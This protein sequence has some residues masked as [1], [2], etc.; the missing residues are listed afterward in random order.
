MELCI[1]TAVIICLKN[2]GLETDMHCSC[3]PSPRNLWKENRL[4]I[5]LNWFGSALVLPKTCSRVLPPRYAPR[6]TAEQGQQFMRWACLY[7][8]FWKCWERSM[9]RRCFRMGRPTVRV[10]RSYNRQEYVLQASAPLSLS[11]VYQAASGGGH[12][13]IRLECNLPH[14]FS[15]GS[16]VSQYIQ[17]AFFLQSAQRL[18]NFTSGHTFSKPRT[19]ITVGTRGAARWPPTPLKMSILVLW[20]FIL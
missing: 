7:G 15:K 8:H 17:S 11:A 13:L 19:G 16:S 10:S 14:S 9:K 1:Y 4:F 2:V 6:G 20:Q 18:F 12:Q 3:P 5:Q